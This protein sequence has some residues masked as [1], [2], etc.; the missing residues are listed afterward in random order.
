[1]PGVSGETRHETP[2]TEGDFSGYWPP[3]TIF[4]LPVSIFR[5]MSSIF[6]IPQSSFSGFPPPI[7]SFCRPSIDFRVM[8]GGFWE[9]FDRFQLPFASFSHQFTIIFVSTS[10][11]ILASIFFQSLK[12]FCCIIRFPTLSL[13]PRPHVFCCMNH[14]VCVHSPFSTKLIFYE[15]Q[16]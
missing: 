16:F 8:L 9:Q 13:N 2:G 1:M 10:S 11:S 14:V 6:Q 7:S 3:G 12:D 15:N 5:I 4:Q